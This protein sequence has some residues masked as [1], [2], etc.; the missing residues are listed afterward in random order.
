LSDR[1]CKANAPTAIEAEITALG[2]S[3]VALGKVDAEANPPASAE[4]PPPTDTGT[5]ETA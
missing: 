2:A 1:T 4:T 3:T 5:Y